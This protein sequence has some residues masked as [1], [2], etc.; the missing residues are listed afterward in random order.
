MPIK[1]N[2][3]IP[4]LF[5]QT[6]NNRFTMPVLLNVL[7]RNELDKHFNI[8][9]I[10]SYQKLQ[11]KLAA[12]GPTLIAYSFMTP[13][14]VEVYREIT[15]LRKMINSQSLIIA[16]GPHVVGDPKGTQKLGFDVISNGEGEVTLP[17]ICEA[18]LEKGVEIRGNVFS[19]DK[20]ISLNDSMPVSKTV[21][22][23]SP[24]EITRGC[25]WHCQFC[26]TSQ[27]K[28]RYRSME[29][30]HE[31]LDELVRR[32]YLL[33]VGFI[34]PSGFE[35]GAEKPGQ[36]HPEL[37][38]EILRMAKE[39]K[40]RFI[41]YGIFPSELRPNTVRKDLLKLIKK[42]CANQKVTIGAQSG[43][44]TVLK[45]LKRGHTTQDIVQAAIHSREVG[46]TPLLD[47]IVG[48]PGETEE[49]QI[50]TL[51][52]AKHLY[53]KYHARTQMHFFI[54]LSGTPL[55]NQTPTFLSKRIKKMLE[56]AHHAGVCTHWWKE[57]MAL[58][59]KIVD[60]QKQFVF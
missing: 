44:D 5:R 13:H 49:E 3:K 10:D 38:E 48:F 23:M 34:C 22:M 53:Q 60:F 2:Q 47:F 41:E 32:N 11:A 14:L 7:E 40:I 43:S 58:S 25:H 39:R 36:L 51:E 37:L 42:Y 45:R 56:K 24:L 9:L 52:L 6:E 29:S 1:Q 33:R 30:I 55:E 4:L 8:Q 50:Q 26:Q 18:F 21:P 57:G 19:N 31:Y 59:K 46:L 27:I 12:V 16:G 15:N 20:R 28:P 17:Q 35:Y 54:P